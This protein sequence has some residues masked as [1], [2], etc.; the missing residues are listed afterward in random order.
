M[1]LLSILLDI[2]KCIEMEQDENGRLYVPK[3]V[4][5]YL[6]STNLLNEAATDES[7]SKDHICGRVS[8]FH[9]TV[10]GCKHA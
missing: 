7:S 3:D 9:F 5:M 10:F 2:I 8:P 1:L 4:W 6:V